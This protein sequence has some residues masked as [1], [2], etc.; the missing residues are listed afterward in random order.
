MY[1][2][3]SY[4]V[5][6]S[7]LLQLLI[8]TVFAEEIPQP[9]TIEV[10]GTGQIMV[11]PNVAS[12]S[13]TVETTARNADEAVKENAKR[14]EQVIKSLKAM[15][16]EGDALKTSAYT[17]SPVYEKGKRTHPAGYRAQSTL[18][19]KTRS[20]E[21]VGN[22]I[23]ESVKAGASGIG[24]LRFSHDDMEMLKNAAAVR[25]VQQAVQSAQQ[26]AKV[27]GLTIKR[28]LRISYGPETRRFSRGME[29][30][31]VATTPVEV[32][33]ISVEASVLVVFDVEQEV[34]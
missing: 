19:L 18:F 1:R 14:A 25:A 23:D 8:S 32:G 10:V 13:F 12:L 16:G 26:L 9:A 30:A 29:A 20:L 24:S 3:L 7:L 27:S 2:K 17:V 6:C 15:L 28:I 21:K 33:K 11:M 5:I 22:F 4:V 31:N 34:Q